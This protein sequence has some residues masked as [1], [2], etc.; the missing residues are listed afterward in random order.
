M[1]RLS[2]LCIVLLLLLT[3]CSVSEPCRRELM[4]MDTFM[5]LSEIGR[6][7]CR[8]RVYREV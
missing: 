3:G 8:E 5:T 6:A 2:L 1:R 4:A 7:S